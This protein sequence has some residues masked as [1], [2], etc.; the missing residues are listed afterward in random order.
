VVAKNKNARV[1]GSWLDSEVTRR[2]FLKTSGALAGAAVAGDLLL[3]DNPALAQNFG[4]PDFLHT[5]AKVEIKYSVCLGCHS[6]CDIRCKIVDGVLVKIDGNPYRPNNLEPHLDYDTDPEVAKRTPARICAKGQAGIQVL[7][8]PYR[9]KDPLKRVGPRGSGEWQIISWDQAFTEMAAVLTP[10]RELTAA[11]KGDQPELGPVANQVIF[12]GGR[13][14]HG[15]KDFTDRFWGNSFGTQNK[16]GDHTSICEAS[17]HVGYEMATGKG[18]AAKTKASPDL[19]NCEFVLWFGSDPLSANFPFAALARKLTA[20][21]KRGG[22]LAVVD[23]RCNVAASKANWWLPIMPGTDAALALGI[24]RHIIDSG[25]YSANFLRRPHDGAANPTGELNT[26]DATFLVKIVNG[27]PQE[28]LRADEAGIPGGTGADFVVW[29]SGAAVQYDTQ[30]TADLM[31]GQQTVNGHV[32]K[33]AFEI[34]VEEVRTRTIAEYAG[35]CGIDENT[36]KE[37]AKELANNGHGK[38]VS[39]DYYRGPVQHTNGT[40]NALAIISLNTMVGNFNWKGGHVFGGSHWHETGGKPGND[41]T[42]ATVLGGVTPSGIRITRVKEQ[43]ENSTDFARNGYPARRPWFPFAYH[44]NYQEIIPSIE[45][46][47]PYP[48]GALILYWNNVAYS[49]PAARETARRVLTNE[50]LVP[51]CVSIDIEMGETTA[52]VD[53]ILPDTTYLE[54][55]STPHVASTIL[56]DTS[57]V[58]QPVVGTVDPTTGAYAPFLP[59][60][61][62]MEDI[63]I[64]LG[65]KMGLPMSGQDNNGNL[66]FVNTAWDWHKQ[67]IGNIAGEDGGPGIDYVLAR[68]GRFENY[69]QAYDGDK[70]AHRFSTRIYFFCE[71]L[72]QARDSMTGNWFDGHAK[73]V[74]IADL[75]DNPIETIDAAYPLTVITYKQAWHSMART[76]CNPWLVAI[77][78]ENFVEMNSVDAAARG[79]RT[80]DL[81]RLTSASSATGAVGR[82]YVTETIRPG[83]VAAAHSFGHW[84]MSSKAHK[85][86]GADRAFDATRTAGITANPIM[87]ADPIKTNV[88]LQDKVGGSVAF[89]NTRVQVAKA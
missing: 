88:S 17:H 83:V 66:I 52:L 1:D 72:A 42:P 84:E 50:N 14:E 55:W 35:I 19:A 54:R 48:C 76:I 87:R 65:K 10:L 71:V 67:L 6:A 36:I 79:I 62:M 8:N 68:G 49:T 41:Y 32:C 37:I 85:V 15:Q 2:S 29:E 23:P 73:Y 28:F 60:T 59:G 3:R 81:V 27:R 58:R 43:Y 70:V 13:N 75:M 22:K 25:W 46:Q 39:V 47:Y 38:R 82:A 61:K 44:L 4:N 80:G 30:D 20:M 34:Y 16:R 64:G 5:D 9:I 51:Y 31:P 18:I 69:D 77:Q 89:F 63:H 26:T 78:P 33:T 45:D 53:L 56:T 57:G 12:S 40:Y 7:Y 86:N 74:P 11:I 24:A 21:L